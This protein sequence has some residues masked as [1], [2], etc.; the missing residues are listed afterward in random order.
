LKVRKDIL[1]LSESIKEEVVK[2]RRHFHMYPELSGREFNT[3][4]F[5]S[6]KLKEFGVDEVIESFAGSTAVVATIK[7]RGKNFVALRA[8]MDALPMEEKGDKP[9]IS[10]KKGIMH[11]C[12]HDAHTAML[13][14]AARVLCAMKDRLLGNVRLIFQPCEERHDCKG[15]KHLVEN[16]A[17]DGVSAIYALH[18]FPDLECGKVGTR[19]GPFLASSDEFEITIKG[20]STH[21]ARPHEGV[22]PIL[23]AAQVIN[24]LH[25]IVSRR[26][27]PLNPAVLTIG[28]IEGGY[29]PNII[30]DTVRMEGTIRTLNFKD[31]GSIPG[32]IENTLKHISLAYGGDYSFSMREG[33][34]PLINDEVTTG[35][36]IGKMK[37]LLGDEN[38]VILEK[39]TMGGEDFSAYLEKVPG[40]FIRLG[41]RNEEKGI[42][43][44]LHNSLFDIDEDALPIGVSVLSYLAVKW[45]EVNA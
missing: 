36:A 26:I 45:L 9:Y 3:S 19:I 40:T 13:L 15:A 24:S 33:T 25:H 44:P 6:E 32:M 34:P 27:D 41:T 7:G 16:G 1:E 30:P 42:I 35:F 28:R 5:V 10:R 4:E 31:R 12:G 29:A 11:A 17:V 22:D 43:Y 21:A 18:V 23:I 39:P 37:E 20:K 2:W 8:D 14:G 38:V